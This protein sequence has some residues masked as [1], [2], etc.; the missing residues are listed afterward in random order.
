MSDK[1]IWEKLQEDWQSMSPTVDPVALRRQ[2]HRKRRRMQMLQ[3][4][5]V[6]LGLVATGVLVKQVL[7]MPLPHMRALFWI[8]LVVVWVSVAAGAWLRRS[9]W[10]PQGMEIESLL[11][12]TVRRA[13][14]GLRFVWFN[15][16]GLLTVD[17]IWLGFFGHLFSGGTPLQRAAFLG[18]VV[19]IAIVYA[20]AI[21][22]AVWY[23]RRQ[24]RKLRQAQALLEQL[25]QDAE[26]DL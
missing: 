18:A 24:R 11:D 5:D 21:V 4:L 6:V 26:N 8:L 3:A 1:A 7:P 10:K 20:L 22:W 19:S 13:R 9:T 12:L 15:L 14:A 2:I 25:G 23:G 17:A 16:L